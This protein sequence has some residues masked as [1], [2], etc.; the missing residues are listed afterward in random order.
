VKK[1]FLGSVV[2]PLD[3]LK[4]KDMSRDAWY[5]L[6]PKSKLAKSRAHNSPVT[7]IVLY[8]LRV[9]W[10]KSFHDRARFELL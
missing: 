3:E 10:S 6:T 9:G 2:I 4:T 5:K 1:K 8:S 7:V